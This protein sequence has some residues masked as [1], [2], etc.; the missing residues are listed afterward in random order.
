MRDCT[1]MLD[2]DVVVER[3]RVVDKRMIVHRVPR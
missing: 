1:V 2:G 3:G